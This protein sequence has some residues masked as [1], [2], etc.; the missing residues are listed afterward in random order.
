ML[1]SN[2]SEKISLSLKYLYFIAKFFFRSIKVLDENDHAPV[3]ES[4]SQKEPACTSITEFHD[5]KEIVTTIRASD[6]D[7]PATPNGQLR[8]EIRGGSAA[9]LFM[10]K[11]VDP[12]NA[13]IYARTKLNK[14]YGNYSLDINIKDLGTPQKSIEMKL[15]ICI[16]DY[17]D[18]APFF[19]SP[20]NNYTIRVAEVIGIKFSSALNEINV[21][22]SSERNSWPINRSSL[23]QR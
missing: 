18:H 22:N 13:N 21:L 23:R 4:P 2:S 16:Q 7:D 20:I 19:V 12:W 3:V 17:N 10:M 11:Q 8:F 9:D 5:S 6:A 15:D 1:S 14:L